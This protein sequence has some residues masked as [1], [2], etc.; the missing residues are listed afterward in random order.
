MPAREKLSVGPIQAEGPRTTAFLAVILAAALG[1]VFYLGKL[2][3]LVDAC[4]GLR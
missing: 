2:S 1:A 3:A 4:F